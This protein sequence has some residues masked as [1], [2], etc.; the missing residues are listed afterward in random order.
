MKTHYQVLGLPPSCTQEEITYTY[1]ELARVNHPDVGGDTEAFT[2]LALAR[3]VLSDKRSRAS[4]DTKLEITYDK[5]KKCD[6]RGVVYSV[7]N[8]PSKCKQC[9]GGGY[10]DKP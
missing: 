8:V 2:Q 7:R 6:G 5:C 9:N 1:R 10:H 4:Y 3:S